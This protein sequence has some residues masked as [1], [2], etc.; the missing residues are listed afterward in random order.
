MHSEPDNTK[1]AR[2]NRRGPLAVLAVAAALA[3]IV[4][5]HLT[6]VIGPSSH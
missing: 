3:L 5:L 1:P 4:V 6:G 2:T